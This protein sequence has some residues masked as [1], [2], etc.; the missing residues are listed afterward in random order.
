MSLI[1]LKTEPDATAEGARPGGFEDE[2]EDEEQAA[3]VHDPL[4]MVAADDEELLADM[5]SLPRS[6]TGGPHGQQEADEI[7]LIGTEGFVLA[8]PEYLSAQESELLIK[9]TVTK[10]R[11]IGYASTL[12][13]DAAA[14]E[15]DDDHRLEMLQALWATLITRL[16]T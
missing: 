10:I 8:T 13:R 7:G 11:D 3:T 1:Q 9:D 12:A 6:P 16:A 2:G 15:K 4:K 14:P 5:A